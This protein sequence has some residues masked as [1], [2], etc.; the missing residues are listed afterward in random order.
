MIFRQLFDGVSSTYAYLI[1]SRSGGEA[2]VIDPVLEKVD[3]Y[4][5]LIG[6]LDLNISGCMNA[7]GH[8]HIGHIGILGV[9]KSGSEWYQIEI[10]GQQGEHAAL[11]KVIGP[12]FAQDDVPDVIEKL[13]E[14]YLA[15]RDSEAERFVD[16]VGRIGAEPFK[17]YVYAKHHQ[18]R[19]GRRGHVVAG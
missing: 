14:V 9:D 17:E 19:Q 15:R 8:H 12:S 1:A 18:E 3:R 11:G 6:E 10:G 5:H 2:L 13:I 7:C 16:T 4:L